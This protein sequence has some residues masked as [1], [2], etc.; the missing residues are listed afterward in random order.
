[1]ADTQRLLAQAEADQAI[2]RLAIWRALLASASLSGDLSAFL[3]QAS[4][5]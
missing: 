4:A 1:V 2:S 3:Q 5:P